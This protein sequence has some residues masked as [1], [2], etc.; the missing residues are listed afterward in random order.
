M[1]NTDQAFK[2]YT[3][4]RASNIYDVSPGDDI[5]EKYVDRLEPRFMNDF[6]LGPYLQGDVTISG[7]AFSRL[8]N[9]IRII[10][11]REIINCYKM[12]YDT[13]S[14][15]NIDYSNTIFLLHTYE[16]RFDLL[17]P[18][19]PQPKPLTIN[20]VGNPK[21]ALQLLNLPDTNPTQEQL[22]EDFKQ[23][24]DLEYTERGGT[25]D[26]AYVVYQDPDD[27]RNALEK[28]DINKYGPGVILKFIPRGQ[29]KP[30]NPADKPTFKGDNKG[31]KFRYYGP[32]PVPKSATNE[33]AIKNAF[34]KLKGKAL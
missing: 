21:R 3:I 23:Y 30:Y 18:T 34:E 13:N 28:F 6:S 32:G 31:N 12:V 27:A 15:M 14:G 25:S 2:D 33:G 4:E 7:F 16:N 22:W 29:P 5:Y 8:N 17:L 26:L 10:S 19:V 11:F 24:G 20:S 1:N 9:N